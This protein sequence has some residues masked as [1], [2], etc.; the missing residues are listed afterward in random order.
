VL[1]AGLLAWRSSQWRPV[2][3]GLLGLPVLGLLSG[4]G[5]AALVVPMTLAAVA[6]LWSATGSAG[7]SGVLGWWWRAD[8][9][10]WAVG[11]LA[12]AWAVG[13]AL[14]PRGPLPA[15]AAAARAWLAANLPPGTPVRAETRTRVMLAARPGDWSRFAVPGDCLLRPGPACAAHWWVAGPGDP[16]TLEPPSTVVAR[17]GPGAAAVSVR[18][19]DVPGTDPGAE[20]RSRVLAGTA[21]TQSPWLSMD[22]AEARRLRAGDLDPRAC[23]VLAAL[24]GQQHVRLVAL[25]P[26]PGEQ[27]TGA[28]VRQLVLAPDGPAPDGGGPA[29][30]RRAIDEFFR[31]QI[32]PFRPY[33]MAQT[34]SG[35][36]VRYSPSAPAG[37][38]GAFLPHP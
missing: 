31:A 7:E 25:P 17:F 8:R 35:V 32:R 14:L 24:V 36:L 10:T 38:L 26:V 1:V 12:V 2:G 28:P 11:V 4:A 9:R 5:V 16:A 37:L 3:A 34:P 23:T 19:L 33:A 27:D 21:V 20:R 22:P 15:P 6:G 13:Y 29:E 18:V 30:A